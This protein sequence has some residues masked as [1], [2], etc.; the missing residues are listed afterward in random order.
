[1][2]MSNAD[3]PRPN[4]ISAPLTQRERDVQKRPSLAPYIGVS[5][6]HK[7]LKHQLLA[8]SDQIASSFARFGI[9]ILPPPRSVSLIARD[10]LV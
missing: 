5:K 10:G 1:M 2:T 9:C 3:R 6:A 4:A 7:V 8:P